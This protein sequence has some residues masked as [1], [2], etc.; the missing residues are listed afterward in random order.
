MGQLGPH[1]IH[2]GHLD[3]AVILLDDIAADDPPRQAVSA[4]RSDPR[5]PPR[6]HSPTAADPGS[7]LRA[8]QL[9]VENALKTAPP[10][11]RTTLTEKAV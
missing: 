9:L 7:S 2:Y 4:Y 11:I 8:R 1:P 5:L 6:P 3:P 10:A